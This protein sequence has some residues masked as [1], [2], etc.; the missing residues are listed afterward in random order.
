M[1]EKIKIIPIAAESLGVR[2]MCTLVET[3]DIRILLDAGVSLC[4]YRFNLMP[5]PLEFQTINHMRKK[6]E[7]IVRNVEII[8]ISHYHFDHHT[9]SNQDWLVNWTSQNLSAKR[10]YYQKQV[11]IKDPDNFI[12]ERQKQRAIEFQKITG[13]YA[14]KITIADGKTFNLGKSTILKFSKAVPHGPED[15]SLGWIIMTNIKFKDECFLFAPDIQGP[16]SND[17]RDLILSANPYIV[18]IGGPPFYLINKKVDPIKIK[19]GLLNLEKIVKRIPITIL[20]H[21]S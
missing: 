15:K 19:S 18:Q 2:S 3:P 16:M 21:H 14:K 17:T 4:P 10:I 9:P 5:H 13:K 12:T 20:E 7:K 1:L 6:M 11:L 8:T